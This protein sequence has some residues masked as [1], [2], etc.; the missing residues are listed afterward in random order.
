MRLAD[1][2][3]ELGQVDD[4]ADAVEG[5]ANGQVGDVRLRNAARPVFL[6]ALAERIGRP[7]ILV[8]PDEARAGELVRDVQ[9]WGSDIEVMPLPDPDQPAYSQ[10]AVNQAILN[11]RVA[12]LSRL[13]SI[14]PGGERGRGLVVVASVLGRPTP[15][16][17]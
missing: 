6:A 16:R 5:A 4:F 11:Q 3:A 7:L 8:V 1:I 10:M 13:A 12:V 17:S 15:P 2:R 9:A 14:E